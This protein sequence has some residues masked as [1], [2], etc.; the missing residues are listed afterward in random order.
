MNKEINK[1]IYKGKNAWWFILLFVFYNA[2]PI[3][4]GLENSDIFSNIGWVL[5]WCVYYSFNILFIPILFRNYVVLYDDYFTLYFGFSKERFEL[6]DILKIKKSKNPIAS[7]ANSLDRIHIL[8][9]DKDVY[10]ALK[11]NDDFIK[12]VTD[13]KH[14]I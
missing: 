8:T 2:C 13:K 10:I 14:I 7:S 3:L 1:K 6:K 12:E 11:N 4:I 5:M 9:K